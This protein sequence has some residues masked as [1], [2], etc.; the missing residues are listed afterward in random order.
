MPSALPHMLELDPAKVVTAPEETTIFRIAQPSDTKTLP[1]PSAARPS[2]LENCA[3]GPMP[4]TVPCMPGEPAR[5]V[6][7]PVDTT[8]FRIVKLLLSATNRL[9]VPS[10]AIA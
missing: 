3:A 7:S 10:V 5:V 1:A 4:S 8:I 6:T 2:G 9:P